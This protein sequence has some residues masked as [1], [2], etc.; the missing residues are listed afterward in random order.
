MSRKTR[1]QAASDRFVQAILWASAAGAIGLAILI[2]CVL[3]RD[4]IT[5]A[6]WMATR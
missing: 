6:L 4:A 1:S 3:G 2:V 5:L